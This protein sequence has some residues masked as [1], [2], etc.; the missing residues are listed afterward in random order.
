MLQQSA[1][2]LIQ[3]L[4]ENQMVGQSFFAEHYNNSTP[5]QVMRALRQKTGEQ[6][7]ANK[8]SQKKQRA[9]M[10]K[11][12]QEAQQEEEINRMREEAKEAKENEKKRQQEIDKEVT[13]QLGDMIQSEG[14]EENA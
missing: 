11:A 14:G 9:A 10:L 6:A 13:R 5:D 4:M 7:E 8:E 2:K 12:Q 3:F 1:N